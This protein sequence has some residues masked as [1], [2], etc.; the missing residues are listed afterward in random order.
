MEYTVTTL[1]LRRLAHICRILVIA[2]EAKNSNKTELH[3]KVEM[4]TFSLDVPAVWTCVSTPL[5][6]LDK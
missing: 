1:E 6:S 3:T 2:T 4:N 5:G